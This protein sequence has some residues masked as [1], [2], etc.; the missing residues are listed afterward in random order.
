MLQLSQGNGAT[1]RMRDF[2]GGAIIK[3]IDSA[4]KKL[5]VRPCDDIPF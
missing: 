5:A 3:F 2:Y 1:H 4:K